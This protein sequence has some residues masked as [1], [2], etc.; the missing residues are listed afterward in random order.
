MMPVSRRVLG[1][2]N[3]LTLRLSYNYARAL[4]NDPDATLDQLRE[5]ELILDDAARTARRVLGGAHPLTSAIEHYRQDA[6]ENLRA[7][8]ASRA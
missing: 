6:Q 5:A 2:S 8:E 4:Y 1:R 3:V 7:R